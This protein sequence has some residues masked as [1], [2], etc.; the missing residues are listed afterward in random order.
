MSPAEKDR[1]KIEE[2]E[3][4]LAVALRRILL[5]EQE[6]QSNREKG[7]SNAGH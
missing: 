5:E 2:F 6:L 3:R 4:R 7:E 1:L